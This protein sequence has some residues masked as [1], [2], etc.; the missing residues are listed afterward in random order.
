MTLCRI[1]VFS[2]PVIWTAIGISPGLSEQA[3]VVSPLS[4]LPFVI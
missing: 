3:T 2:G 1:P 4:L